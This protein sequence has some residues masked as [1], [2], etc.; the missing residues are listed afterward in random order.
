ML[1]IEDTKKILNDP[2]MSDEEATKI[3]DGFRALVEII[4]EQ[5]LYEKNAN[6]NPDSAL[7]N[8]TK[9][10]LYDGDAGPPKN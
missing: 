10:F 4:F 6:K 9:D 3:R 7:L 8:K 1:S 5:W 2:N